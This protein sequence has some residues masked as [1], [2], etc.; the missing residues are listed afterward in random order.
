MRRHVLRESSGLPILREVR[1]PRHE[2]PGPR[3]P[4][5]IREPASSSSAPDRRCATPLRR[6]PSAQTAWSLPRGRR[7]G[8]ARRRPSRLRQAV[9][10][11]RARPA[12]RSSGRPSS[13]A[14]TPN[15]TVSPG[16]DPESEVVRQ[17]SSGREQTPWRPPQADDDLGARHGEAL[18]GA[19]VE[20]N[21]LPPPRI[22]AEPDSG[23]R[24]D[25]RIG[26]DAT[27]LPVAAELSTNDVLG[28]QSA[29]WPSG[30]S[31]FRPAATRCPFS[32]AAPSRDCSTAGRGGSG[33]R[34]GSRPS[35]RRRRRA[36]G[37][38][39]PPPS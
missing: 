27:L 6:S 33:R 13:I 1:R 14:V 5:R 12:G 32:P 26:G 30:L 16:D 8:R 28:L 7:S 38:R 36:P 25:L 18:S 15:A 31:P 23:E 24:L 11:P 39:S 9:G 21:A 37:C 20:R 34:R 19:D 4:A 2:R 29:E 10:S 22:D 35:R 3:S 17:G